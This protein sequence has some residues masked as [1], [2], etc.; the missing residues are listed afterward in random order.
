METLQKEQVQQRVSLRVSL[1][2]RQPGQGQEG[3]CGLRGSAEPGGVIGLTPGSPRRNFC[4]SSTGF[5]GNYFLSYGS[6]QVG[7][8]GGKASI[9]HVLRRRSSSYQL[10]T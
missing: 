3:S 9:N 8:H 6:T 2:S 10:S 5:L 1:G 7:M 4:L